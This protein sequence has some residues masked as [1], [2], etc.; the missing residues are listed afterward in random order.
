M[1]FQHTHDWIFN[2]SPYTGAVKTCT[3]RA[4]G[5]FD[6]AYRTK[7]NHSYKTL[8]PD[9]LVLDS[10]YEVVASRNLDSR[11]WQV[12][13]YEIGRFYAVQPARGAK[14]IGQ[15]QL[16]KIQL[17]RPIDISF[18]NAQ[19][20]GFAG[21]LHYQT[22]IEELHGKGAIEKAFWLLKFKA[23]NS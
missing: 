12:K 19:A 22:K 14:S 11:V 17:I 6:I 10:F 1:I 23:V 9:A 3:T 5:K 4:L 20:E 18:D 8:T 15:I 7:E 16:L 21:F 13:K 2:P